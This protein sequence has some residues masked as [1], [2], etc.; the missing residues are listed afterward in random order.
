MSMFILA[1][2]LLIFLSYFFS[3]LFEK[4]KIPDVL[5]LMILGIIA[6]PLLG[7]MSPDFFGDFGNVLTTLALIVI[8]FE[9][10][11]TID[12]KTLGQS[13]GPT[14]IITMLTFIATMAVGFIF[15]L[16]ILQLEALP[17]LMLGAI[18]GGTS[19]AVVVP[20]VKGL[21]MKEPASTIL[22]LESAI[23]DVLCIVLVAALI[24]THQRGGGASGQIAGSIMASLVFAVVIGLIGGLGWLYIISKVDRFRRSM[25]STVAAVLIGYGVAEQLGFSGAITALSFGFTLT[26]F[27][28]FR[29]D[30]LPLMKNIS[31]A[32]ISEQEK[33]FYREIV[34]LLKTFF[35]LFLGLSIRFESILSFVAALGLVVIIYAARM[36]ICRFTVSRKI[37]RKEVTVM[38]IM[39]PKGLAAAV[40]AGIPLQA[41]VSGGDV[42]RN[43]VFA[44]VLI[45]IVLTAVLVPLVDKTRLQTFY[46]QF[47]SAFAQDL[48]PVSAT[49]IKNE[50]S[51]ENTPKGDNNKNN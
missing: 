32:V 26:N 31:F 49:V 2:G 43:V 13:I 24:D 3:S 47:F 41:G 45:S 50:M 23:T 16:M 18:I 44:V 42:I 36:V 19:S 14:M 8:L 22:I 25:F 48:P 5:L 7:L 51:I 38:S 21:N 12:L 40:L 17:S 11:T 46:Y 15:S 9:G 6:G 28:S 39:V 35:F 1:I 29:F 37:Q 10:G 33:S 4:T 27:K 30:R 20:M 34:F